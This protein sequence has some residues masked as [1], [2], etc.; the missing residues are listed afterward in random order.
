MWPKPVPDALNHDDLDIDEDEKDTDEDGNVYAEDREGWY[1]PGPSTALWSLAGYPLFPPPTSIS[2]SPGEITG[3]E[4][5]G[6]A[7]E[8]SI[9]QTQH[10]W[11]FRLNNGL[12]GSCM[13]SFTVQDLNKLI[14]HPSNLAPGD[15]LTCFKNKIEPRWGDPLSAMIGGKFDHGDEICGAVVSVREGHEKIALWTKNASNEAAQLSI[16][17]QWKE[18]LDYKDTIGFIFHEDAKKRDRNAENRYTI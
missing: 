11:T 13:T 12:V 14:R 15:Y 6:Q 18:F 9:T 2:T 3:E 17:K 5:E 8:S 1:V 7:S 4:G 16:G 10:Q